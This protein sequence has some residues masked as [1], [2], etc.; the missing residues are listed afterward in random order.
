MRFE[1]SYYG[2]VTFSWWVD[3]PIRWWEGRESNPEE[4][5]RGQYQGESHDR[6]TL[7]FV[8]QNILGW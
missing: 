4:T 8:A 6:V 3:D 5:S 7:C 2:H 1:D